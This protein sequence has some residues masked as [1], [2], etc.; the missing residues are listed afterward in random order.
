MGNRREKS[1]PDFLRP[2]LATKIDHAKKVVKRVCE[3]FLDSENRAFVQ[4]SLKN[5]YPLKTLKNHM[6]F[7]VANLLLI[8]QN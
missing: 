4:A 3:K 7:T 5:T 1:L 8:Y 6:P 2:S